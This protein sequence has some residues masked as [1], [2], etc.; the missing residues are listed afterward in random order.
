MLKWVLDKYYNRPLLY[1]CIISSIVMIGVYIIDKSFNLDLKLKENS[2]N[3][4]S[5]GLTIS[6]F[7][8]TLLTIL[9][10]VKSNNI[11][12]GEDS[13]TSNNAFHIFLSSPLYSKSITILKSGVLILLFISFGTLAIS[14]LG[15]ELYSKFGFYINAIC[16]LFILITFLRCFH[17]INMILRMQNNYLK[18]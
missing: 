1:D 16:L 5:I 4:G 6:G 9:L 10:T 13:K 8:M 12:R 11:I 17:V 14:V 2:P 15:K 7:I 3:L 18:K